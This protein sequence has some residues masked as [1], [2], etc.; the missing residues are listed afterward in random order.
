MPLS[1]SVIRRYTPPTCTLEVLAQSSPLSRWMG[2]PVLK[3]LTFELRFD[4]PALPEERRVPIRGDR[5]QL[6]ALCDAVTT[7]VQELLQ[8]S[9]ESFCF[10]FSGLQDSNLVSN[11]TELTDF[12]PEPLLAKTSNNSTSPIPGSK[13]YLESTNYLT[14]NLYLG[15]LA[16]QTSGAVI[17][18]SLLQLFDLANALDEYTADVLALPILNQ[19]SSVVRFPTW[20]TVAAMFVIAIGLTPFT[21]QYA[22]NLRTKPTQ[23]A[24]TADSPDTQIALQTPPAPN[25]PVP[26]TQLT[27]NTSSSLPLTSTPPLPE[28]NSLPINSLP[29]PGAN[30]PNTNTNTA[31]APNAVAEKQT[32]NSSPIQIPSGSSNSSLNIPDQLTIQSNPPIAGNSNELGIPL[33][34]D[35]PPRLASTPPAPVPPPL[36][37]LPNPSPRTIP[38]LYSPTTVQQSQARI[39]SSITTSSDEAETNSLAGRLRGEANRPAPTEVSVNSNSTLFDTPQVAE[40]RDF[41]KKRWQPPTGFD[42]TLEYSVMVGVDGSIE[43]I[44]PLGKAARENFDMVG[45]PAIGERFVSANRYGKSMRIRV[46]LSPDGKVQTFPESE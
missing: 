2:K 39:S 40:A 43:R 30:L 28:T 46:V 12:S 36:A 16:N 14:H 4:D 25:F 9:P 41:L 44:D 7:Y 13:I 19:G 35:L 45:M 3:Q 18:L 32:T 31:L 29:S 42:Q 20:V 37:T 8:Q 22:S 26:Q 17:P 34:R 38:R 10:S 15:S 11:D 24:K 6:E 33:K 21:W 5:D 1:N 23:T 27:P